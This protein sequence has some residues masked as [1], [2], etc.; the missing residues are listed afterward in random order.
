M[1]LVAKS[2]KF[3]KKFEGFTGKPTRLSPGFLY[4]S[5]ILRLTSVASLV[6]AGTSG[7]LGKR[8][9]NSKTRE[10]IGW[11]PKYSSFSHFLGVS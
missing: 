10:E 5:I 1:D 6:F 3:S 4:E 9:N 11:E 7:P 8:L 2:G